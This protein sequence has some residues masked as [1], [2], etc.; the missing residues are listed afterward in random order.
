MGGRDATLML[1][2]SN[3]SGSARAQVIL[4]C[5]RLIEMKAFQLNNVDSGGY[6]VFPAALA[7]SVPTQGSAIFWFNTLSDGS[8]DFSTAQTHCPVVLGKKLGKVPMETMQLLSL[9]IVTH[10]K[11]PFRSCSQMAQLFKWKMLAHPQGSI[12]NTG[13]RQGITYVQF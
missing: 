8:A 9:N 2:V 4:Y 6:T 1:N 12:P 3:D 5:A 10:F 11:P 13:Q 7:T